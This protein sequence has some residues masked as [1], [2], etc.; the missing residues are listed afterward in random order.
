MRHWGSN[1]M[2]LDDL[3]G[4][5]DE[6]IYEDDRSTRR[7]FWKRIAYTFRERQIYLRSDGSVQFLVVR[8]WVQ[9][10]V[11]IFLVAGHFVAWPMPR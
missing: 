2:S 6:I 4:P 8:P 10:L 5:D 11:S 9:I 3:I 7:G 1:Q